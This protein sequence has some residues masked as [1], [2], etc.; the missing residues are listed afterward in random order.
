MFDNPRVAE[1]VRFT[2]AAAGIVDRNSR[3]T[4]GLCPRSQAGRKGAGENKTGEASVTA[5]C[6]SRS[7]HFMIAK[8]F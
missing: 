5:G 2:G 1:L 6:D 3:K 7:R 8:T 4:W